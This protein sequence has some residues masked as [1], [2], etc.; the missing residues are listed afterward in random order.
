MRKQ[1]CGQYAPDSTLLKFLSP[2][3]SPFFSYRIP[4]SS[5]P[6]GD[7]NDE[8]ERIDWTGAVLPVLVSTPR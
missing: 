3:F 5:L 7:Y 4:T 1:P 8:L 6:E 2:F